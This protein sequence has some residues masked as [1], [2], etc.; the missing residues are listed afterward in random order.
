VAARY[1]DDDQSD[2]D[3]DDD[4]NK[5]IDAAYQNVRL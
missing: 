3:S 2:S 5:E 1:D 4:D